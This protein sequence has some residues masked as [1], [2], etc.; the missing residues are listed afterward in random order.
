VS[1][2]KDLGSLSHAELAML[3]AHGHAEIE[4]RLGAVLAEED[5]RLWPA[6]I[7]DA[8]KSV[9]GP[10]I[11]NA[12]GR[13]YKALD[14]RIRHCLNVWDEKYELNAE[15][16]EY[17]DKVI[18]RAILSAASGDNKYALALHQ[19]EQAVNHEVVHAGFKARAGEVAGTVNVELK[20][21]EK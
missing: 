15:Q 1:T 3:V 4:R 14:R 16:L 2:A 17:A 12:Q 6:A 11:F 18:C 13:T 9:F 20:E 21:V 19:L 8:A 7:F 5:V 10:S